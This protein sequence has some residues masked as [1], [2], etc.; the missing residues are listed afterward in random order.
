M[1]GSALRQENWFPE[2]VKKEVF[3]LSWERKTE[4]R[5]LL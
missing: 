4:I 1:R 5:L 3:I 2:Q